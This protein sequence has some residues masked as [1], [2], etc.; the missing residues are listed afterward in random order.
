MA[1][2]SPLAQLNFARPTVSDAAATA[3]RAA[4]V[5]AHT[6]ASTKSTTQETHTKSPMETS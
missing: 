4:A 2:E 5:L 1:Q 6:D 3:I